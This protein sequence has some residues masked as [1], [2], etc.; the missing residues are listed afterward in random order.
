MSD[1]LAKGTVEWEGRRVTVEGPEDFV[2]AELGRFR[3]TAAGTDPAA[4]V[5]AEKQRPT[6]DAAF[7]ALK[8]PQDHYEKVDGEWKIVNKIYTVEQF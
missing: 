2:S 4:G 1:A 3:G 8:K 7:V 6:T 5:E